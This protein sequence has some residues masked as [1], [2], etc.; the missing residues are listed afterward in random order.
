MNAQP[1]NPSRA[2]RRASAWLLLWACAA[3]ATFVACSADK[4]VVSPT[5]APGAPAYWESEVPSEPDRSLPERM[6]NP[7]SAPIRPE[8]STDKFLW[9]DGTGLP[10]GP[11][12]QAALRDPNKGGGSSSVEDAVDKVDGG[13]DGGTRDGG[14]PP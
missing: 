7:G 5:P 10:G 3:A 13:S 1:A 8:G 14:S 2:C 6:P 11:E 9:Q 4:K 12:S